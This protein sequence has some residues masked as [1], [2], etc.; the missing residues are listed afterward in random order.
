MRIAY[1]EAAKMGQSLPTKRVLDIYEKLSDEGME[2]L[3]LKL[4][5]EYYR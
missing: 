1:E 5:A 2:D 3:A 4:Y